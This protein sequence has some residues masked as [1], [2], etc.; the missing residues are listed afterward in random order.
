MAEAVLENEATLT[1]D[2]VEFF[3]EHGFL[4][5]PQVFSP[6]EIDEMADDLDWLISTWANKG[7]GW[8][9]G[10]P[11]LVVHGRRAREADQGPFPTTI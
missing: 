10:R 5:I 2:Q 11:G 4:H 3:Q 9:G 8:S 1:D 6:A 7:P